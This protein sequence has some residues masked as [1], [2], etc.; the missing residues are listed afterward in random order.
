M[1]YEPG[2]IAN[3]KDERPPRPQHFPAPWLGAANMNGVDMAF[4]P[5]Q[6]PMPES[7]APGLPLARHPSATGRQAA[8]TAQGAAPP[9]VSVRLVHDED[10][11][12][13]GD[14]AR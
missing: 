4:P 8:D 14:D 10:L 1:A 3:P 5:D 7:R 6:V 9:L 2:D 11:I 13:H 12:V